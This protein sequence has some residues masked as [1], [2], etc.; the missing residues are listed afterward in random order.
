MQR[1]Q[2]HSQGLRCVTADAIVAAGNGAALVQGPS[3]IEAGG[4][5]VGGAGRVAVVGAVT[6]AVIGAGEVT[7][8]CAGVGNGQAPTVGAGEGAAGKVAGI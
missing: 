4:V 7:G 8:V 5:V 2:Y 1:K 6:D 3:G